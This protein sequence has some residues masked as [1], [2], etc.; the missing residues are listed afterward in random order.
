MRRVHG[1]TRRQR[2][3]VALR[4]AAAAHARSARELCGCEFRPTE[5]GRDD[6]SHEAEQREPEMEETLH[7]MRKF[8]LT[9]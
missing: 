9:F 1:T 3:M 2:V 7:A 5:N 6:E 4:H 8:G